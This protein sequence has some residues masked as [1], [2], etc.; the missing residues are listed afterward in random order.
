LANPPAETGREALA[1]AVE[2]VDDARL[3]IVLGSD[4]EQA[5]VEA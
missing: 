4:H 5:S 3:E 2:E 1:R